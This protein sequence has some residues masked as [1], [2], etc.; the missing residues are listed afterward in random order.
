MAK[1]IKIIIVILIIALLAVLGFYFSKN[2]RGLVGNDRDEHGCIG[3][4]GYSWCEAKRL[5]VRPWEQYCTA[6]TPKK[7]LFVCDNQKTIAAAFYIT[8]DKFVDL[9]LS[10]GRKLSAP[11]AISASGARY[12][13]AD[14]TFVFWNKGD[15]A[16]ITEGASSTPTFTN[17]VLKTDQQAYTNNKF[18]YSVDYPSD[19]TFREFPDT[20]TGAGFRPLNS[21][22]EIASECV[23]VDARGTAANEYD[24]P[25]DEYVK[26]AGATE[27]QNYEKLNSIKP[28]T[29]ADGSIGYET[30]WIYKS[31]D[32]P[33]KVSLPIT[34][35]EN[36]KT[37]QTQNS[38]LKYKTV[39]ITLN[40]KNCEEIYNQIISTFD[41]LK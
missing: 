29:T 19:W 3:S 33:E 7:V 31:F 21:S 22:D 6:A 2:D 26:K 28:I 35:F 4:A 23:T 36:Q 27:I 32:G 20:Q 17:C 16:F 9:I 38:Q 30:T 13:N 34:Y 12:A 37:I 41:I 24:T 8:D 18:G 25:F 39:Q 11:R 14:E 40:D 5:C 1:N 10:D 15:T